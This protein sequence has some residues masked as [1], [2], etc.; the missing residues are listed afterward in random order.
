M[1][2]DILIIKHGALGDIVLA[3]G[4]MQAIRS[5]HPDARITCLT[6]KAYV[7]LLSSC[8]FIDDVWQDDKPKP[9]QVSQWLRLRKLLRSRRFTRVYDLQTSSRSTLYWWLFPCPKP[10]WSGIGRFAS[11]AQKGR[12]RHAMHTTG[13]LNGQLH[14]AGIETSGKPDIAWLAAPIDAFHLPQRFALIVPGGAAHRPEKRWPATHYITLCTRLLTQG[15]TPA[16]I[17]TD[18][19]RTV[20]EGITKAVPDAIDLCGKTSIAQ[21]ASLARMAV[22]AV[23]NDTGP[24]HIIGAAN[25]PSTVLFSYAS[26]PQRSAPN[27]AAVTC[28]QENDLASLSPDAVWA[29]RPAGLDT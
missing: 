13:R 26:S 2:E 22:W 15:I 14:I 1:S 19:E 24:M 8:P 17:G 6:G 3:S 25:C 7:K 5:H 16:L 11:H 20:I 27:G 10:E 9:L 21:L 18:A 29:T 4:H 12:E 23:G 28:L